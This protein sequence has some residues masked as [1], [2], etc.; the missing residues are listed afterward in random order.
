MPHEHN[1]NGG[2]SR[3]VH[4]NILMQKAAPLCCADGGV[5][6]DINVSEA[7]GFY[8]SPQTSAS[9][10]IQSLTDKRK[11]RHIHMYSTIQLYYTA[12]E[13]RLGILYS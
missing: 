2:K 4:G 11:I 8:S 1:E 7:G 3:A 6:H 5:H 12:I 9:S 13:N 10:Q